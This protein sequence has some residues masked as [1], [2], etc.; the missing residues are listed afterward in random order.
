MTNS[1]M[2]TIC[3]EMN[4][5]INTNGQIPKS[6]F[7]NQWHDL[8]NEFWI[9]VFWEALKINET[10]QYNLNNWITKDIERLLNHIQVCGQLH[11]NILN[12]DLSAKLPLAA[13]QIETW[14]VKT[15]LWRTM[16]QLREY[17]CE[18]NKIDLPNDDSS[19]GKLDDDDDPFDQMFT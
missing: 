9:D 5:Y 2:T 1:A 4:D 8:D 19:V 6:S 7:I 18:V 15:V 14:T 10:T 11:H 17:Y 13:K 12:P 16:M 3:S